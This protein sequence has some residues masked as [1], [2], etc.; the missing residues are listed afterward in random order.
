VEQPKL[1]LQY[2]KQ[3]A[4]TRR[5]LDQ[6][7]SELDLCR[8]E[9]DKMI[10]TDPGEYKID[11]V[12]E[13]AIENCIVT[14]TEYVEAMDKVLDAKHA[15]DINQAFVTALDHRKRALENLVDLHGQSYF[16]T[17]RASHE[18]REEMQDAEERIIRK[19]GQRVRQSSQEEDE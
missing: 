5:D 17:P 11:K 19:R 15:V 10:R 2:A 13:K 7:K 14:Q 12:S 6:A 9:L 16:A 8:A 4:D 3:L 1:Y 18:N